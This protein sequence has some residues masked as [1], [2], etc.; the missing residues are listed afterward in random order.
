MKE[1]DEAQ[2]A[3]VIDGNAVGARVRAGLTD[4]VAELQSAGMSPP[5]LGVIL[6]GDDPASQSYVRSKER[7]CKDAGVFSDT[8]R[9]P[10]TSS[11]DEVIAQVNELNGDDRFHGILVQLPL[12]DH[13]DEDEVIRTILPSKDV[14]GLHPENAGLLL[15]GTPRFVPATP[16]GVQRL[17][18]EEQVATSGAKVV[19]C[20]RSNIVGLPLAA[21]F[22]GRGRGANATVTVCH[23]GTRDLAAETLQADILVAAVGRPGMI[24]GDMVKPGAVVIDVGISRVDDSTRRR[25]YRLAGDVEYDQ[26]SRVASALTPVPGGVGPMTIAM[27]IHNVVLARRLAG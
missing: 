11:Q 17:L 25:G 8:I 20:G 15:A 5:G 7:A 9:M 21:L 16:L 4:E 27:L 1:Q 10:A 3:R 18:I 19:I 23:T 13:V 24:T 12:P 14:D 6:V 22:L 26:V 2:R